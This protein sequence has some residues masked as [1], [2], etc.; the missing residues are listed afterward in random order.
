MAK[1]ETVPPNGSAV[2][3]I[4]PPLFKP[5]EAPA[6]PAK[7]AGAL[8]LHGVDC[9]VYDANILGICDLLE[10]PAP[11]DDTWSRRALRHL[12]AHLAGLR[13]RNLYA[14]FDAY[15]R[16]VMDVNRV[17]QISG[18]RHG[19]ALSLSNHTRSDRSP[20]RSG[21]LLQAA[22]RFA[23]DPFYS[24]FERRLTD[25][26]LEKEPRVVGISI[27]YLSQ[28]LCG[29]AMAG[30]IRSRWPAVRIVGGG[31]LITSWMRIPGFSNP[32]AGLFDD[33]V[34]GP[35]EARLL[36][37]CGVDPGM[38][39]PAFRFDYS[40]LMP[41]RYLSP[42]TILPVSTARGCWW[43][44][45]TFCP[46][47]AES[48]RYRPSGGRAVM[49][50]LERSASDLSPVL[51]HFLDNALAPGFMKRLIRQPPGV[52]WYGFARITRHLADADF[53]AGLR[54]SG[55]VMLKL[56][57]ESGDP[58]VLE[59]LGKGV[60]PG[61]A[62]LA[63]KT[64]RNAGIATYVYLL[65]GTPAENEQGARKTLDFI[66]AHGD[67]IDFLNLAVFNLPAH[68]RQ[69]GQLDTLDFYDGDLSLYREFRHPGGWD[70]SRVRQFL[71]R[72]FTRHRAIR[73]ILAADPPYFTSNHA[74][75]FRMPPQ[76]SGGKPSAAPL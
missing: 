7:L 8:R 20:V 12:D 42:G 32:F 57:V 58:A 66:A 49:A 74:P 54:A 56:G 21:D 9:R 27:N 4:H 75:F 48:G 11:A 15:K 34:A 44:K 43:R 65:F 10:H 50:D 30:F 6:G 3:L 59:A 35:G 62:S 38:G 39:T 17:L 25:L 69:A 55:C 5:C 67:A 64:L 1:P 23:D 31:G 36:A 40:G 53:A 26:F 47:Q 2:L 76:E 61:Q 28:A 52:P 73:P 70:R 19:A 45:C 72:E 14:R 71:S 13:S 18:G 16:A 68:G 33:L 37:L 22:E 46:E 63:L 51:I 24:S 41:D 29:F 60:T